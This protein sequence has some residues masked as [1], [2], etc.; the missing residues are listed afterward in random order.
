MVEFENKNILSRI[1]KP[2]VNFECN[3]YTFSEE[4]LYLKSRHEY[5]MPGEC[6]NEWTGLMKYLNN[7]GYL[8]INAYIPKVCA[9]GICYSTSYVKEKEIFKNPI[10]IK[11]TDK[12]GISSEHNS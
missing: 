7:L 11:F 1:I 10:N 3:K 6:A 2:P 5:G 8:E 4:K 12:S 9:S